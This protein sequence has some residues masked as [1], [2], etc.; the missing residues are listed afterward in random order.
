MERHR[1]LPR[2]RDGVL[3]L[4]GLLLL[5]GPL[6]GCQRAAD[7][8][9]SA[10]VAESPSRRYELRGQILTTQGHIVQIFHEPI[11]DYV[12]ESGA[13]V[14][15]DSMVMTWPLGDGVDADGLAA[16]DV[17]AFV[18]EVDWDRSPSAVVV[19]L[20][21]LPPETELELGAASPPPPVER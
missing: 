14:G 21:P 12:D 19:S 11:H 20:E 6:L 5:F 4:A 7:P 10:G 15:M 2:A 3:G 17:V 1:P 9:P 18:L 13:V 8:E 16:T